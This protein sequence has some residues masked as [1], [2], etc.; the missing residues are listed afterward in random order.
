MQ[1]VMR[2]QIATHYLSTMWQILR[3]MNG[4]LTG[5]L[6]NTNEIMTSPEGKN[7]L[8][9]TNFILA[10]GL[11]HT[12]RM[13]LKEFLDLSAAEVK[14]LTDPREGTGL[15]CAGSLRIPVDN[16]IDRHKHPELFN[17]INTKGKTAA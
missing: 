2:S 9:N 12:D 3:A 1:Y 8:G 4:V 17:M 11:S 16:F 5:I 7:I 15:L 6:Q 14:L 13:N 10:M